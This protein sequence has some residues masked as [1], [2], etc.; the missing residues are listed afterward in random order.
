MKQ[1]IIIVIL[2]V[3]AVLLAVG[4]DFNKKRGMQHQPPPNTSEVNDN[5]YRFA[6]DIPDSFE[7]VTPTYGNLADQIIQ[8]QTPRTAYP[9]TNFVDAAFNVSAEPSPTLLDCLDRGENKESFKNTQYINGAI[10]YK[11]ESKEAAAGNIYDS[12]MFRIYDNG[13]CIELQETVHTGNIANYENDVKEVDSRKVWEELDK[14]LYT[15]RF[16]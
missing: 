2:A 11:Q 8:A 14:V 13:N 9:D 1:T 3:I 15:F 7:R 12:R 10:F 4:I 5:K 16:Q 6:V